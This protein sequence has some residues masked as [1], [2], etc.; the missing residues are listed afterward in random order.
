MSNNFLE[1]MSNLNVLSIE[2]QNLLLT[3]F[4]T[5]GENDKEKYEST[6]K[7]LKCD[8]FFNKK[9]IENILI[10]KYKEWIKIFNFE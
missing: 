7:I 1:S 10:P 6:N 2:K 9:Q 8:T 3:C 4:K 5:L